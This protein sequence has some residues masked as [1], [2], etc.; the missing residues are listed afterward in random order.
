[1]GN[2]QMHNATRRGASCA[3][4]CVAKNRLLF[5]GLCGK[6]EKISKN[7]FSIY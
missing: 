1:M 7:L 6:M 5:G 4:F 2:E 3:G